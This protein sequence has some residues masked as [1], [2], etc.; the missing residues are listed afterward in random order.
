[1]LQNLFIAVCVLG[2]IVAVQSLLITR[3][4]RGSLALWMALS[5]LNQ[6][7][8]EIELPSVDRRRRTKTYMSLEPGVRSG[9]AFV[10]PVSGLCIDCG[11]QND[12]PDGLYCPSC[13]EERGLVARADARSLIEE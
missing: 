9:E 5:D 12:D 11:G 4:L 3:L 13:R 10:H 8:E 1:M 2:A 6:R 7:V